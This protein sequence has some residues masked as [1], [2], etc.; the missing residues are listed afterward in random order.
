VVSVVIVAILATVAVR[1]LRGANETSR[2]EKTKQALNRLATAIAGNFHDPANTGQIINGY[3]GDVGA[4]PPNLDALVT[5]PGGYATWNGPYLQDLFSYGGSPDLFKRDGWGGL[6]AY[7][8][9]LTLT[10]TGGGTTITRSL[11]AS[12]NDLLRNQ[13]KTTVLDATKNPPGDSHKDSVRC[14]ILVP[15]GSGGITTK[16]SYPNRNGLV[17]F[18]SIPSGAH[19]MQ[20]IYLPTSDTVRRSLL[21][22]PGE[23]NYFNVSLAEELW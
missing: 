18:D 21:V 11:G 6:I 4:L 2:T 10:A 13:V 22:M 19:D 12:L 1:S 9:G 17:V 5:N 15:N 8:G 7:S 3:V 16:T 14:Q 20:V 23:V